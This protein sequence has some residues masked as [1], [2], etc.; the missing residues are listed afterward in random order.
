MHPLSVPAFQKARVRITA[1]FRNLASGNITVPSTIK[2]FGPGGPVMLQNQFLCIDGESV[3]L[4][5]LHGQVAV[6]G[7]ENHLAPPRAGAWKSYS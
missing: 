3:L 6:A 1:D 5:K 7:I 2:A 4:L